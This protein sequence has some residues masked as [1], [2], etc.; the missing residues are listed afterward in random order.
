MTHWVLYEGTNSINLSRENKKKARKKLSSV[1]RIPEK[2]KFNHKGCRFWRRSDR[3]LKIGFPTLY[4]TTKQ[5]YANCLTGTPI[6]IK[7]FTKYYF[8][9]I[10]PF[11][12]Y[13]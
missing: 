5:L 3:N 10:A 9:F 7:A 4:K 6:H 8:N 2:T 11:I 12:Q 1:I 13:N